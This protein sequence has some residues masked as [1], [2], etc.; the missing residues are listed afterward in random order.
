MD[1]NI[2]DLNNKK[3]DKYIFEIDEIFKLIEK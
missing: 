1:L 2:V 3:I